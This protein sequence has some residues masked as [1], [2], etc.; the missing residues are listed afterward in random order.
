M[1]LEIMKPELSK[2]LIPFFLHRIHAGFPSPTLEGIE[3]KIDLNEM[4]IKNEISTYFF[5]SSGDFAFDSR[6]LDGDI[7]IVDRAGEIKDSSIL[8]IAM[9]GE[10]RIKTVFI[11]KGI[12]LINGEKLEDELIPLDRNSDVDL[13]GVVTFVIHSV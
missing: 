11:R 4:L 10:L 6:I 8:I 13:W 7:L 9:N 5:R 1:K 12:Y 3:K 2:M